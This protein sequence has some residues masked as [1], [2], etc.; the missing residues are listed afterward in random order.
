MKLKKFIV[1]A[2]CLAFI[3]SFLSACDAKDSGSGSGSEGTDPV[4]NEF[5]T[6]VWKNY[7]GAVLETDLNVAKG[8]M[9]TYDGSIPTRESDA[10]FN[11]SFVG[12]SP[13][14]TTVV[15]DAVYVAQ[16]SN[17]LNEY[18]VIWKNYDGTVLETDLNVPY[19]TMPTYDGGLPYKEGNAQF[20]YS[21]SGWSPEV[22]TVSQDVIYTAQF[23][24]GTNEYTITWKNY[25]GTVLETDLNVPYGTMPTYDGLA[26]Q[27][28]KT[29]QYSYTFIGWSPEITTVT[30][31]ASYT[32]VFNDSVNSYTVTWKNYNDEILEID[33]N[34][35]YG[36]MPTFNSE[37]PVKQSDEQYYYVFSGWSPQVSEVTGD[38]TYIAQFTN[39]T[40]CY[41]I[42]WKNFDGTVLETDLN[43]PYGTMP[44]YDGATP[45][46]GSTAQYTFTFSGWSPVVESVTGDATYTAV[47]DQTVNGYTITWKNYDGSV[48]E[49]DSNVPYGTMPSYDG[50]TPLK[51]NTAQYSYTFTGWSPVVESVTGDATYTA[52]F[53]DS[54]NGY[55]ITWINHDGT[56]LEKD[57]NVLY[58]TMPTY[59]G[60]T[61]AKN[62]TAQYTFTFTGWSPVVESV[63]GDAT[64]MAQFSNT[65]NNYTVT[66]KNYDGTILEVDVDVPFGTLPTYDGEQ[67]TKDRTPQYSYIFDGWNPSVD[68]V[69]GDAIYV[70]K[71]REVVNQ[72]RVDFVNYDLSPLYSVSVDYGTSA[73]Y[74]G[75]TPTREDA[76]YK[77]YVFKGWNVSLSNITEDTI[78]V[79]Q[80]TVYDVYTFVFAD[81]TNTTVRILEGT[82]IAENMPQNT[83]TVTSVNVETSYSWV[84]DGTNRFRES[85]LSRGFYFVTYNLNG[86]TNSQSN[87]TKVYS[88][89]SYTLY[90][91]SKNGYMFAGWYLEDSFA[92]QIETISN[93]SE[94]ISVFA[95]FTPIVY[96]ITYHLYGSTNA[97][98]NPDYYTIEDEISLKNPTKTG[99][100]FIG[101]YTDSQMTNSI[102]VISNRTGNID[103]YAK[104]SANQYS[105]TFVDDY[106]TYSDRQL[107][108]TMV[109]NNGSSNTVKSINAGG[110]YN[111]YSS[112]PKK[113]NYVFEGWYKESS[114]NNKITGNMTITEDTTIYAKFVSKNTSYSMMAE[115][116]SYKATSTGSSITMVIPDNVNKIYVSWYLKAQFKWTSLSNYTSI[117]GSCSCTV[118]SGASCSDSV[119]A[120]MGSGSSGTKYATT[121][122][123][124][125]LDCKPGDTVRFY[126]SGYLDSSYIT[127][128]TSST[129][130]A[131]IT[132]STTTRTTSYYYDDAFSLHA[133]NPTRTGY[134][135]GGWIDESGNLVGENWNYDGNQTF[136]AQWNPISYSITYVLNGGTN[137]DSNPPTYTIEDTFDL[138]AA[139]KPGYSFE[140]WYSDPN[141]NNKITSISSRTGDLTLYARYTVN[142]YQLTLDASS[143]DG[144]FAPKVTFISDEQVIKTEYL[145]DAETITSFYPNEKDGYVFAGW[146]L[147]S[148]FSS[149]FNFTGTITDDITLYAKWIDFNGGS[150]KADIDNSYNL[151]INGKDENL[152]A[153]TPISNGSITITSI[154][155]L[156][157]VGSL[158]DSSKNPLISADDISDT[159]LN[160]SFTYNVQAGHTYYISVKGNTV[161][162]VGDAT[163]SISWSGN[164]TISGVT[165]YTRT[166]TVTYEDYF[167][168]PDNVERDG[169]VFIGWF[170]DNGNQYY[171]GQWLYTDSLTLHAVFEPLP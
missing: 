145:H 4:V 64:Y 61:P 169:Y 94:N 86:G 78:A 31:D 46:K 92:N 40:Q 45:S 122:G 115:G 63:T 110:S 162:T 148:E 141:Y 132:S 135:F 15:A 43:V 166:I 54:I 124:K 133:P 77:S 16:Y 153:F 49:I 80:Y 114:F 121:S 164:T 20:S 101:W 118:S 171:G 42:T 82:D 93:A 59:D 123:N 117:R 33:S 57:F 28:Q 125:T 17:T 168:L 156:D 105:A 87:P 163:L 143:N 88:D 37:D 106:G 85:S 50:A 19:G 72:Y 32:A 27:K 137:S 158:L 150:I 100:T 60:E 70:A 39:V 12:W 23:S 2:I 149:P 35:P 104:F 55:T 7:D 128:R 8:S 127:V 14:V 68:N 56:V 119:E 139:S 47:F 96:S 146:Y 90:N 95:K 152:I 36:T 159:N 52:T 144:Q 160:F 116:T 79:A 38:I 9:P 51:T 140:G 66:W 112:Y 131:T 24:E 26:P 111:P 155:E 84:A 76:N 22:T 3:P 109:N 130:T 29:A 18:T 1:T 147:D 67:P 41:T 10:Q 73:S 126:A 129:Q 97:A 98:K 62:S 6:V 13:S 69:Q 75:S 81:G 107:N 134:T 157:L 53:S 138:L 34:V 71:F 170:D 5:Y 74:V 151:S 91:A 165:Y 161:S 99:Y 120:Y 154:S 48:L 44:S 83:E 142:S 30:G 113:T 108:L 102:S 103:L 58:G 65:V 136:T 167:Y 89:E 25:D 21:F 11:Y